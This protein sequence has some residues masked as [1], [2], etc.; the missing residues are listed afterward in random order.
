MFSASGECET[1]SGIIYIYINKA[2]ALV[3]A[4]YYACFCAE[5]S[6][7]FDLGRPCDSV[8]TETCINFIVLIYYLPQIGIAH[9]TSWM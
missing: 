9:F 2:H 5:T 4:E 3:L 1:L 8:R 6:F 7:D